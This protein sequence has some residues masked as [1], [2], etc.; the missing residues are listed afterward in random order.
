[1]RVVGSP[2]LDRY[3]AEPD[4]RSP[5]CCTVL[6][7]TQGL[8]V[9]RLTAFLAA[10]LQH[11]SQ[12]VPLR[13]VIKLHPIHEADKRPYLDALSSF[14]DQLEVLAGSEGPS[15]FDWLRRAH[16]HVSIASASHYDAIGLGVPTVVLPLQTHELVLPLCRAGHAHLADTPEALADLVLAWRTLRLPE[17]VSEYYFEAGARA[18]IRRELDLPVEEGI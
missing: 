5:D 8:D 17:S 14:C 7:T 9:E 11:L 2:R 10:A 15:T 12:R 6:V 18:N 4:L 16:L 3:R 13:L 1:L